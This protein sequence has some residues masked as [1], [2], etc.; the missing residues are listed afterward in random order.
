[1]EGYRGRKRQIRQKQTKRQFTRNVIPD[2]DKGFFYTL[3][4]F[5]FYGTF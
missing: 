4:R 1:M 2:L 5:F 3:L